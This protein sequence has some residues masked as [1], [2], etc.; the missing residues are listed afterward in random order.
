MD[1]AQLVKMAVEGDARAFEALVGKY[2]GIVYGYAYHN[3]GS[4]A[5]AQDLAQ[6]VLL[7]A[8]RKLEDLKDPSR[9]AGWLRGY[10]SYIHMVHPDEGQDLLRQ[11]EELLGEEPSP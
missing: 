1:D 9:F 11:V 10:A 8:Y 6:D 3:T 4:F 5:D 7:Q 2:Q